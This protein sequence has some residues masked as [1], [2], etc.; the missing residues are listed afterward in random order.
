M[1]GSIACAY[2]TQLMAAQ[3]DP[4]RHRT[5]VVQGCASPINLWE[6]S[7]CHLLRRRQGRKLLPRSLV[8]NMNLIVRLCAGLSGRRLDSMGRLSPCDTTLGDCHLILLERLPIR[9]RGFRSLKL[10]STPLSL[11]SHK[12]RPRLLNTQKAL[13]RSSF[14]PEL[15]FPTLRTIDAVIIPRA[16]DI[17][18]TQNAKS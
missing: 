15:S 3:V 13:Y 14:E 11:V 2:S 17:W 12:R 1:H 9:R 5:S 8:V 6:D 18:I 7:Q 16:S 4:I 10:T